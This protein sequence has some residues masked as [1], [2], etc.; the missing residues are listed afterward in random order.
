MRIN[1][2]ISSRTY[3]SA[4]VV[5]L[6]LILILFTILCAKESIISSESSVSEMNMLTATTQITVT[7]TDVWLGLLE[8]TP[9][10][11]TTPL[12]NSTWTPID[13]TYAKLD[14]SEPQWWACRRCADYRPAG[15][16]WKL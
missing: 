7:P 15:G 2:L 9:I 8:K 16:I 14:L 11:H 5:G 4:A 12:P 13:G 6:S 3:I 10:A 1:K